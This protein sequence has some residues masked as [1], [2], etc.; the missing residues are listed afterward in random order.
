MCGYDCKQRV[1]INSSASTTK[2]VVAG[3]PQGSIEGPL[4][5]KIFINDLVLFVQYVTLG[6]Y[7]DDSN[8]SVSRSNKENLRNCCFWT[9]CS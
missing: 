5:F 1:V 8:I 4:L 2:T 6:S 3:V 7:T 9:N